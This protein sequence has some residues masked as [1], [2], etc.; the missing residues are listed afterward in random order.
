MAAAGLHTHTYRQTRSAQSSSASE[1]QQD[2]A[3]VVP[4]S[5]GISPT[6]ARLEE[7]CTITPIKPVQSECQC[8]TSKAPCLHRCS[9]PS[10]PYPSWCMYPA[11]LFPLRGTSP[12]RPSHP[13]CCTNSATA[14]S[15]TG[16]APAQHQPSTSTS[17]SNWHYQQLTLLQV[18]SPSL[19]VSPSTTAQFNQPS[20]HPPSSVFRIDTGRRFFDLVRSRPSIPGWLH[21][22]PCSSSSSCRSSFSS[23][24][25]PRR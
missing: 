18:P 23:P 16:P 3:G 21:G 15:T 1:E 17:T 14:Q 12:V 5:G 10:P 7:H 11:A 13:Q 9:I 6:I 20:I 24:P 25:A 22:L 2:S 4:V 8:R 19:F